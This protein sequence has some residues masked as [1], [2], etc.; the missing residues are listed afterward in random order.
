MKLNNKGFAI[1]GIL[2]SFI[3]LFLLMLLLILMNLTSKKMVLDKQKTDVLN[4]INSEEEAS[5]MYRELLLNGAYPE[6]YSGLIPVVISD[7]GTVTVAEISQ[8][9]YS[10]EEKKW[11]N[12][13]LINTTDSETKNKYFD[14]NMSLKDEVIGTSIL[15]SEINS[16]Y[17]WIPRYKYKLFNVTDTIVEPLSIDIVFESKST[18]KSE[19]TTI[20][21]YLTHP[22]FSLGSKELNGFWV[23][24]FEITGTN[25]VPTSKPNVAS[26]RNVSLSNFYTIALNFNLLTNSYLS[27][28]HLIKNNEWS[29][30]TYLSSSLYGLNN[31]IV[32]NSNSNYIT[33]CG[34]LPGIVLETNI[35]ENGFGTANLYNQSTT[36]NI[37]GVFDMNGG[38]NE[39]V[40]AGLNVNSL[41]NISLPSQ[42]YYTSYTTTNYITACNGKCLGE[43]LFETKNWYSDESI[44]VSSTSPWML[45]GG[46]YL[47][48]T[49]SGIYSYYSSSEDE[50]DSVSSRVIISKN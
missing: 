6:L 22:A 17:V 27:E 10:Y 5:T 4:E 15:E 43:S 42:E 34:S 40:F 14:S 24:K 28:S 21:N 36:G 49:G 33:G 23:S 38:S 29:S 26:L 37:S 11:A 20:N 46:T 35:C 50:S 41:N 19:F 8:E 18:I 47:G 12:A 44:F 31:E 3:V 39:F 9:W 13:V 2:Y 30:I 32:I 7:D 25:L 1:S 48:E 45:R 16:Y